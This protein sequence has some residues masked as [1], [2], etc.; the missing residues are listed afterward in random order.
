MTA[1][2]DPSLLGPDD[3]EPF[4]IL[5]PD[6]KAK[7]LLVCDHAGSTVPK[8]LQSLGLDPEDFGK[9]YAVDIGVRA[10]TEHLAELMKAPAI[11]ANYSRLVVDLNRPLDH[12]TAFSASGEGKPVPG[13][14]GLG[15]EERGIREAE[16]YHPYHNALT[17]LLD[18][19]ARRN[20]VP[21]VLSIHSFTPV[22]FK[23]RRPWDVGV[24]WVQDRRAADMMMDFFRAK[25][26]NVGDNE[27]Y[28]GRMIQGSTMARHAD[29]RMLPNMLI[30]IRNDLL[31][32]AD[33]CQ[34]WANLLKELMNQILEDESIHTLYAG[35]VFQYDPDVSKA[36]F[37]NL[38]KQAQQADS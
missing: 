22:F 25:G 4:V 11:V 15:A 2:T 19:F 23:Q 34:K 13:N 9:H 35:P 29:A 18:G 7:C 32:S 10:V 27:P 17:G 24:M 21:V 30:E 3:P 5:N 38:N 33:D 14:I 6:S 8:K 20:I 31:Q 36:Y 37:D 26:L 1:K 16:I 12:P 28:D